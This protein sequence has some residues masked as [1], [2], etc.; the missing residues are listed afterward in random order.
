MS[1]KLISE[2]ENPGFLFVGFQEGNQRTNEVHNVIIKT[3]VIEGEMSSNCL[4]KCL[5]LFFLAHHCE[6]RSK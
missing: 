4:L 6:A 5:S 2:S 3:L 1:Q